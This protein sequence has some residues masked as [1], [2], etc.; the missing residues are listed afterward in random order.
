MSVGLFLLLSLLHVSPQRC[1][2]HSIKDGQTGVASS[3]KGSV[4]NYCQT[5]NVNLHAKVQSGRFEGMLL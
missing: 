4:C 2:C 5:W 1:I 3:F